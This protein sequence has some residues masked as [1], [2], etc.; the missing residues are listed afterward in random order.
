MDKYNICRLFVNPDEHNISGGK[1][2][3]TCI[4]QTEFWEARRKDELAAVAKQYGI[5]DPSDLLGFVSF[6]RGL[7]DSTNPTTLKQL[8][9]I[10]EANKGGYL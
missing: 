5:C 8:A 6:A 1:F 3:M 9:Q 4:T 7:M 2:P 10:I